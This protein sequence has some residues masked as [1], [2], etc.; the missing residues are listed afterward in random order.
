ML[1]QFLFIAIF[2]PFFPSFLPARLLNH[3]DPI[4]L[5]ARYY[6]V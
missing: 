3:L 2:E 1:E 6:L 5:A 4:D